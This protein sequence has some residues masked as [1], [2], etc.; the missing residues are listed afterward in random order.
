MELI[1]NVFQQNKKEKELNSAVLKIMTI[2]E[3]DKFKDNLCNVQQDGKAMIFKLFQTHGQFC[4]SRPWEVIFVSL[5]LVVCVA[6]MT[7]VEPELSFRQKGSYQNKIDVMSSDTVVMSITKCVSLIYTYIQFSKLRR[8]GSKYFL[9]ITVFLTMLFSFG[10][11]IAVGNFLGADLNQLS[12]ALPFFLLLLDLSK[13]CTLAKFALSSETQVDVVK[14]IG[15]GMALVGPLLTLD[16]LVETLLIGVGTLSGLYQ[17]ICTLQ[18]MCSFGCLSVITNY[19]AFMLFYPSCL[20]IV[21][22][23]GALTRDNRRMVQIQQLAKV[24]QTED[25]DQKPNPVVQKIKIIMSTGL[26]FV[27][28]HSRFFDK[29][30]TATSFMGDLVPEP[31]ANQ[32]STSDL[33]SASAD[34][35]H[36]YPNQKFW[37]FLIYRSTTLTIDY[38]MTL[39]LT[40]LLLIKYIFIDT[41]Y[42]QSLSSASDE[43]TPI[44]THDSLSKFF[45]DSSDEDD[46]DGDDGGDDVK[47]ELV[48]AECQT[49][50]QNVCDESLPSSSKISTSANLKCGSSR[51][52]EECAELLKAV[53]GPEQLTDEEVMMLVGSKH[54][55]TYRLEHAVNNFE[56]GVDIRRKILSKA[57]PDPDSLDNLPFMGYDYKY[58]DGACC[59]NVIGY[60]PIPV[61][62]AGPLLINGRRYNVPMATTEGCLVAST[63]RGCRALSSGEGVHSQVINDGMTRAPLVRFQSGRR[64]SQVK[65]WLEREEN[66]KIVA[67]VFNSTSR[68]A[69]LHKLQIS[70]ISRNLYIRFVARTGDAMGMNMLSKGSERALL[71]LQE[72]YFNDMEILSLSGNFCTDKKPSA[73]N[74]IEGRGKSVICEAVVPSHVIRDVLKTS[75]ASLVDLNL[76]KNLVGSVAAG[77]IGGFNAHAANVVT[78]IYLATGQDPAQNVC[79]SNCVTLMEALHNPETKTDDLYIS[80]TMPSVEVGTIGGGTVLPP[81]CACLEML[82]VRGSNAEEPGLNARTLANIVCSTVMAGELSLMSALATGHLVKSHLK[83]NRSSINISLSQSSPCVPKS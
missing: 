36:Y 16:A 6:S 81:Q 8:L 38:V 3:I 19:L 34:P 25:E 82:G 9:A 20:S 71:S 35:H 64:A 26:V 7:Y 17:C 66:F 68:F 31:L 75:V 77:S 54:I 49:D 78:A 57:L 73:V 74:W 10:I 33:L 29:S 59:E 63:N 5:T 37:Q 55:P 32:A 65:G 58:V 23:V 53:N 14:N 11:S 4:A 1:K 24:W 39:S 18:A 42:N 61:G 51:S 67:E 48:D 46:E 45:L 12:E 28:A 13:A 47:S 80:C 62:V 41:D 21:L 70:Q 60:M 72:E 27:H 79:S 2:K 52:L 40:L 43:S 50:D 76:N 15:H 56:R 22:E 44:V 69:R 30:T 83:H